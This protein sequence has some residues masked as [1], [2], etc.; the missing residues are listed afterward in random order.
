MFQPAFFRFC[1]K[2]TLVVSCFKSVVTKRRTKLIFSVALPMRMRLAS[3]WNT[4]SRIQC[5][6]SMLQWLRIE[7]AN[8][9]TFASLLQ[10]NQNVHTICFSLDSAH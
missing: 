9:P 10:P 1:F 3:S 6:L 5:M 2:L 4:T 7:C 8:S